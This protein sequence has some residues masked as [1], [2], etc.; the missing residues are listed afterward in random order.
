MDICINQF[1]NYQNINAVKIR[2][3]INCI[4]FRLYY[5]YGSHFATI[6]EQPNANIVIECD[7]KDVK[8]FGNTPN[9]IIYFN[10]NGH[11]GF[12]RECRMHLPKDQFVDKLIDDYSVFCIGGEYGVSIATELKKELHNKASIRKFF[13]MGDGTNPYSNINKFRSSGDVTIIGLTNNISEGLRDK[14]KDIVQFVWGPISEYR[15]CSRQKYGTFHLYNS[16]RTDVTK[17]VADLLNVSGIIPCS[18]YGSIM[19]NNVNGGGYRFGIIV[20]VAMGGMPQIGLHHKLSGT[21]QRDLNDLNII[22]IITHQKDHRPG[23]YFVSKNEK[24]ELSAIS[25][26]DNDAPT[27]LFP[28][29]NVSFQTYMKCSP[30]VE[31]NRFNRPYISRRI[32]EAINSLTETN[33]KQVLCN[34][35]S[36]IELF[37]LII[38]FNRLKSAINNSYHDGSLK[39]LEDYEWNTNTMK[40]ELSGQFGRTYLDLLLSKI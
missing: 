10:K 12:F 25:A 18:N 21:L 23:N 19:L 5:L 17:K 7:Q 4:K 31:K 6:R 28:T 24:G 20:D 37:A 13:N 14:L 29:F 16:I 22:D 32:W 1:L 30:L 36:R 35:C 27:T 3:L 39:I 9:T 8:F 38:R 11:Q 2:Q 15:F 26:F 40:V 34:S 33:L